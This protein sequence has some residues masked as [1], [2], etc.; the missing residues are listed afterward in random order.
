MTVATGPARD[1]GARG[2][3]G[4]V[5]NADPAG[6]LPPASLAVLSAVPEWWATRA[7]ISSVEAAYPG[8]GRPGWTPEQVVARLPGTRIVLDALLQVLR[9]H[10]LDPRPQ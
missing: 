7:L 6:A 2:S 5:G 9:T 10:G 3:R 4:E 1:M 8:P